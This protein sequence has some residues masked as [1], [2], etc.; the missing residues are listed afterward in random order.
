MELCPSPVRVALLCPN[1]ISVFACYFIVF[2][3]TVLISIGI[4]KLSITTSEF[5][6]DIFIQNCSV[7]LYKV[8]NKR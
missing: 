2:P 6:G 3:F 5:I 4:C 7:A 8:N 1:Y